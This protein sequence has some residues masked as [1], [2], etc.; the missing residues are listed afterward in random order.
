MER[1]GSDDVIVDEC[2]WEGD[3]EK[4]HRNQGFRLKGHIQL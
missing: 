4:A 3:A 2:Y 1:Q